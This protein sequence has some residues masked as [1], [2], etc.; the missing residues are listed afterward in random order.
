VTAGGLSRVAGVPHRG[1]QGQ[2]R[3]HEAADTGSELAARVVLIDLAAVDHDLHGVAPVRGPG[4]AE[5]GGGH[6]AR[7]QCES[8]SG[9]ADRQLGDDEHRG[10]RLA[11]SRLRCPGSRPSRFPGNPLKLPL[12]LGLEIVHLLQG[13]AAGRQSTR[14]LLLGQT[15]LE[16][17]PGGGQT[18][19]DGPLGHPE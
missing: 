10:A 7:A 19:G 17:A 5:G 15:F 8:D 16:L 14:F 9:H 3:G 11:V 13:N 4:A 1:Q 18:G 6:D 2:A 12:Q